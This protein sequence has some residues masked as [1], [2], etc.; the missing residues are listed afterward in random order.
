MLPDAARVLDVLRAPTRL[1]V[2][3][4][5]EALAAQAEVRGVALPSGSRSQPAD[6]ARA[7]GGRIVIRAEGPGLLVVGEGYDPGFS[8]R[9][10]GRPARILRVNARP[11]RRRASGGHAPRRAHAPRPRLRRGAAD[12][13]AHQRGPRARLAARGDGGGLTL[14]K[15]AC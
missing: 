10:D 8:A 9:V 15:R 13:R 7:A 6:V 14:A 1:G 4:R 3:T 11:Y 12:R 5:S 2:D